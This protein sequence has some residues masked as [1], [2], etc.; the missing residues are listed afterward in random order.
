MCTVAALLRVAL[1]PAMTNPQHPK[2]RTDSDCANREF[3]GMLALGVLLLLGLAV[4]AYLA[5]NPWKHWLWSVPGYVAQ[6]LTLGAALCALFGWW[7][8]H[9]KVALAAS[10]AAAAH[11]GL[12]LPDAELRPAP[13]GAQ[14]VVVAA[15]NLH[16]EGAD[17]AP[18]ADWLNHNQTHFA[19]L[20]ELP[21]NLAPL[22]QASHAPYSAVSGNGSPF[23]VLLLSRWPLREVQIDYEVARWLPILTA[24]ACDPQDGRRCVR[25]VGLHTARPLGESAIMQRRQLRRV[26][27]LV[28]DRAADGLPVVLMGDCNATPWSPQ[29]QELQAQTALVNAASE[30][31]WWSSWPAAA[32]GLGLPIDQIL[33]SHDVGVARH[34]TGPH[35]GSDHL[36]VVARLALPLQPTVTASAL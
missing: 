31:L 36:P 18:L 29:L 21:G 5:W 4:A 1:R 28:R 13:A 6:Q 19:L 30:R 16:R 3:H 34:W 20:T 22:L 14:T 9:R 10:V 12:A 26:A 11:L 27:A 7:S 35:L 33:V 32:P 2:P 17:L 8:G 25:L 24:V 23:D 15:Y